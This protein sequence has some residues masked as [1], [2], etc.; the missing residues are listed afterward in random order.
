MDKIHYLMFG[1]FFCG[2]G[3]VLVTTG[4]WLKYNNTYL[5]KN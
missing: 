5:K 1:S 2:V 3:L 4:I